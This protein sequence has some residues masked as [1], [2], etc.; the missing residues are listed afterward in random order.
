MASCWAPPPAR[1]KGA[2]PACLL[3]LLPGTLIAL[4]N[5]PTRDSSNG[6]RRPRVPP[7]GTIAVRV[8][9]LSGAH[10]EVHGRRANPAPGTRMLKTGGTD[11]P[12]PVKSRGVPG[13][14][15]WP[16]TVH[17]VWL[18]PSRW[19]SMPT[20]P[21]LRARRVG[22]HYESSSLPCRP[23]LH[24]PDLPRLPPRGTVR[25]QLNVAPPTRTYNLRLSGHLVGTRGIRPSADDDGS[26][27]WS[28]APRKCPTLLGCTSRPEYRLYH[29]VHF[30]VK[31]FRRRESTPLPS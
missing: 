18:L 7:L 16:V 26:C 27:P 25:E 15:L 6:D 11:R 14:A 17:G 1:P 23:V 4:P 21:L 3:L 20:P 10:G 24:P 30:F 5:A 13:G 28:L 31:L 29:S 2:A 22:G 8:R 9:V 19:N 12:G